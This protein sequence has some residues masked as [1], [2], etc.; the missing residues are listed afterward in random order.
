[1]V[2]QQVA[3]EL[4]TELINTADEMKTMKENAEKAVTTQKRLSE[5]KQVDEVNSSH[6][7]I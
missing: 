4:G 6:I 7:K 3:H 2:Y 1:V 5:T